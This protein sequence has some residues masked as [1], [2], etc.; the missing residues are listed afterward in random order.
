MAGK[1]LHP[2]SVAF[3]DGRLVMID[4]TLLPGELSFLR[5]DTPEETAE[6]IKR[7][8][9]RGAMAIA[10]AG[11]YGVL[12]GAMRDDK[13]P[14]AGARDA[15]H[16]IGAS[17]P[18]AR[19]LFWALERMEK[20]TETDTGG[21]LVERLKAEAD[22]IARDTIETNRRLVECGQELVPEGAR[23]LTHCNSGPLAAL[24]YG[25]AVGI[26]I[27]AYQREKGIE[28]FVDETR[29]LL[30]GARL[31]CW[32][33]GAYG[34]PYTLIPD[35]TAGWLMANGRIDMVI[36]GAD[37]IASNGDSAN[38]IGTYS[39]ATLAAAHNIPFYI[40]APLSTVD[41]ACIAGESIT[42]E[43]R[44]GDEVRRFGGTLVAPED[45][46]VFNPA[47]DVTPARLIEA[48]V[49]EEG[50]CRPPYTESLPDAVRRA[51]GGAW[52]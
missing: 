51:G 36:T 4:Q 29:P 15:A 5:I 1:Q 46:P 9:V 28:V 48:I 43:E 12:L 35:N 41:L 40:A 16:L 27:E 8:A 42:I 39:A 38:K 30:Q 45:A 26:L 7:L 13:D 10:V 21:D 37:R 52:T 24:V 25:T 34:V 6:A 47:F 44:N 2:P 22:A 14:S 19:N 11:A 17:R 33:L 18:T 50:I 3:E 49:T 23:V 31:T 32:E 20:V